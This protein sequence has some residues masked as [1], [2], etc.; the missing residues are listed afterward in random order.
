MKRFHSLFAS[1][2]PQTAS[3]F[4]LL[5]DRQAEWNLTDSQV[6][7]SAE[8]IAHD[9][10]LPLCLSNE[11]VLFAYAKRLFAG[12]DQR[13][14]THKLFGV[15]RPATT[16]AITHRNRLQLV[17]DGYEVD[18]CNPSTLSALVERRPGYSGVRG[19]SDRLQLA[20]TCCS[21]AAPIMW[22]LYLQGGEPINLPVHLR[23]SGSATLLER[24]VFHRRGVDSRQFF[25]EVCP[26]VPIT[27]TLV[28]AKGGE[29]ALQ[30]K[31]TEYNHLPCMVSRLRIPQSVLFDED[32]D[33]D[34]YLGASAGSSGPK[35][36]STLLVGS[37]GDRYVLQNWWKSR[38]F[39]EV[40]YAF[41]E[42]HGAHVHFA[43]PLPGAVSS[44]SVLAVELD[45]EEV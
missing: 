13:E 31:L 43:R 35:M 22:S 29:P 7:Q 17:V 16:E 10:A 15:D 21:L 41:L 4:L 3:A 23:R 9:L 38:P 14:R 34:C 32:E 28:L 30:A 45:C 39:L 6:Q 2:S 1:S 5:R 24:L 36:H 18:T 42:R 44:S 11:L 27:D 33:G 8:L 19:V 37:S 12:L 40:D 20:N 26:Q 25:G